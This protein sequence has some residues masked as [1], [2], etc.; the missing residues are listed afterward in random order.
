MRQKRHKTPCIQRGDIPVHAK[1]K[2]NVIL[3]NEIIIL[4]KVSQKE[5]D[6]YHVMSIIC[7]I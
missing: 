3:C 4:S 1:L 6:K 5:K 7:G 2:D